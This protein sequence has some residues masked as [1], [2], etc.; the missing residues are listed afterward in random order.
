MDTNNEQPF[1]RTPKVL[2]NQQIQPTEKP[3]KIHELCNAKNY[4]IVRIGDGYS[5][6]EEGEENSQELGFV[7]YKAF[8]QSDFMQKF[9]EMMQA[10]QEYF[11]AVNRNS[12]NKR[13]LLIR[14][15]RI[16]GEMI[17]LRAKLFNY[18]QKQ[19]F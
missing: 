9:D 5:I 7:M 16:E 14:T 1:K 15:K 19:L 17:E 13:D 12:P 11:E 8:S 18:V 3:K 2:S 6:K 4:E 10:Q